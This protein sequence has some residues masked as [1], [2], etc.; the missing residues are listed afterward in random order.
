ME[1]VDMAGM[2]TRS[3]STG[4]STGSI[5]YGGNGDSLPV[6]HAHDRS[7]TELSLNLSQRRCQRFF[8]I[9]IHSTPQSVKLVNSGHGSIFLIFARCRVA[10]VSSSDHTAHDA[11]S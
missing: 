1:P 10:N 7:F 5:G 4:I 11:N 3:I 6:P 2:A 8:F 9:R